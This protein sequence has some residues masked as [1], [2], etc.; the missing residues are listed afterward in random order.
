MA[1]G[2]GPGIAL[3]GPPLSFPRPYKNPTTV[4]ESAAGIKHAFRRRAVQVG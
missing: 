2:D 4:R 1:I 3:Q